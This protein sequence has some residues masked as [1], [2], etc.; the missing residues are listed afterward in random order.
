MVLD[1]EAVLG[2]VGAEHDHLVAGVED[3]FEDRVD[4]A[5][6]AVGH[7]EV[8]AGEGDAGAL[9]EAP[10]DRRADLRVAGVRHVA[11]AARAVFRDD[12]AQRGDHGFGRLDVGVADGEIEDILGAALPAELHAGLKH[13][14]NPGGALHLLGD[15]VGD[16]HMRI[17][18]P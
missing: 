10:R 11:V 3:G 1:V 2:E 9:G 5:G 12:A 8:V 13:A 17:S 18:D 14:A 4:G 6:G 7:Q 16:L 15:R